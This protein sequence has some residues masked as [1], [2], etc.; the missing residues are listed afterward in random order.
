MEYG[1][2]CSLGSFLLLLPGSR[3]YKKFSSSH[4]IYLFRKSSLKSSSLFFFAA[5]GRF[6]RE[7][8]LWFRELIVTFDFVVLFVYFRRLLQ[9]VHSLQNFQFFHFWLGICLKVFIRVLHRNYMHGCFLYFSFCYPFWYRYIF[10]VSFN[11]L[12]LHLLLV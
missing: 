6:C 4:L 12:L 10:Y 9:C 7:Y 2:C 8:R 3:V 1:Q 5:G 11:S